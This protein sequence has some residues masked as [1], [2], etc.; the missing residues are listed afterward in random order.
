MS[1]AKVSCC[2]GGR[3]GQFALL[4]FLLVLGTLVAA[5]Q[6]PLGQVGVT[7]SQIAGSGALA[8]TLT[9]DGVTAADL[10]GLEDLSHVALAPEP[11]LTTADFTA[12]DIATHVFTLT[13]AATERIAALEVPTNGRPF[14]VTVDEIPIYAGAFWAPYSSLS[15]DGVV[16]MMMP[17]W[18]AGALFPDGSRTYAVTLGYPGSA[19][20]TGS[21]PRADRRIVDALRV[22]GL[23]D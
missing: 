14:V 8:I 16:I 12:Y 6:A 15:F 2:A 17:G 4:S 21:D 19:F 11:I 23:G 5:C 22:A 18:S 9:A 3:T 20:Y 10:L 1:N 13:V 7:P